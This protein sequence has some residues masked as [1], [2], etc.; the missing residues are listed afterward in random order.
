[1]TNFH[2]GGGDDEGGELNVFPTR[3]VDGEVGEHEQIERWGMT[4]GMYRFKVG[5]YSALALT[6]GIG[7]GT[8]NGCYLSNPSSARE[9]TVNGRPGLEIMYDAH[10][11]QGITIQRPLEQLVKDGPGTYRRP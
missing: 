2:H 7:L 6:A 11:V 3:T 4:I 5:L 1:M 10:H 9:A 8:A